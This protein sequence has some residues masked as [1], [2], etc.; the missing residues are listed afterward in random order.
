MRGAPDRK[1]TIPA[2]GSIAL[3]GRTCAF[4]ACAYQPVASPGS[5]SGGKIGTGGSSGTGGSVSGTGGSN[6]ETGTGG[7]STGSGGAG[8][9]GTDAA[10]GTGGT[11]GGAK[12]PNLNYTKVTIHNRFPA[13]SV[14]IGDF[15]HDR[16][17]A[18]APRQRP[19]KSP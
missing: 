2:L 9:G 1:T 8:G 6:V 17:L 16:T 15:D 4:A 18:I 19:Y 5:G 10:S 12:N 14:A 7:S 3:G 13:A 11:V